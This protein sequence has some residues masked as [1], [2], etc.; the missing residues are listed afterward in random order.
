MT[1]ET[2]DGRVNAVNG[3]DLAVDAGQSLAIVGESGSGKSQIMYAIMGLLSRNGAA[4]GSVVFDGSEILGLGEAALNRI[5][6]SQIAMIFQEPMT[7]LNPYMRISH[8]MIEVLTLHKGMSRRD[9]LA[10]SVRLLDAMEVPE[11]KTRIGMYP[12]RVLGRDAAARAD[13]DGAA[14]PPAPPDCRRA[15]H[16]AR[17]H[18]ARPDHAPARGRAHS[19]SIPP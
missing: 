11:A 19:T 14:L 8:Q 17:R 4:T 10:E 16:G 5:R 15:D 12:A 18:R 3:V 9:A 6:S 1:F 7:S 2:G 13:R